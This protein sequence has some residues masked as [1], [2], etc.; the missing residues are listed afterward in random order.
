MK[1]VVVINGKGG[2]GKDFLC[3]I[4]G[5]HYQTKVISVVDEVKK[6][7]ETC[8][9]K[10]EKTPKA[11]KFLSDL[12]LALE[13]YN[14]LPLMS[15]FEK[16]NTFLQKDE[17]ILFIHMRE[18]N[19]IEMIKQLVNFTG[20]RKSLLITTL[21]IERD[22]LNYCVYGNVA[23]DNVNDYNY[24]YIYKNNCSL[25]EVE[26]DFMRYFENNIIGKEVDNV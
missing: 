9:W 15:V 6:I 19:D 14:S 2:V 21:L 22:S 26:S 16:L 20:M 10:G 3:D 5:K 12:K 11:R 4:V 17:E 24:D 13:N 25:D 18:K 23:D 8:G 7:A 1:Q